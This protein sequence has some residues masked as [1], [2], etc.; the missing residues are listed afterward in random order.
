METSPPN[1]LS[2]PLLPSLERGRNTA[3]ATAYAGLSVKARLEYNI[4]NI[5]YPKGQLF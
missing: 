2:V 4:R 1:P 3:S 5:Q